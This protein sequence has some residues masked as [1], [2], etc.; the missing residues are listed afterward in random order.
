[1]QHWNSVSACIV[2]GL[3]AGTP[4]WIDHGHTILYAHTTQF[5]RSQH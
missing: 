1:M 3:N 2:V 4:A 5:I